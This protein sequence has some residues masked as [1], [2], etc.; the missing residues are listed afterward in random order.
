MLRHSYKYAGRS[1]NLQVST[2]A[3]IDGIA[4]R[5]YRT[6]KTILLN[7]C[8]FLERISRLLIFEEI[9]LSVGCLNGECAL[10]DGGFPAG[11]TTRKTKALHTFTESA[12]N[13]RCFPEKG[14]HPWEDL[15][16]FQTFPQGLKPL[17]K[18]DIYGTAEAVPL[19]KQDL[20][21]RF[22]KRD[23]AK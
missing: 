8:G 14:L 3:I 23:A 19:T 11:M 18:S 20:I 7:P 4:R 5:W 16:K 13:G 17:S 1:G 9:G 15:I 21:Q 10:G 22:L 6:P 12:L 2:R